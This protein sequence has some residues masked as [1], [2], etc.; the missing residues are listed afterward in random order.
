[1]LMA[2]LI[3]AGVSF[4]AGAAAWAQ[5]A[6]DLNGADV[7]IPGT[8][9]APS[10]PS[11]ANIPSPGL[12]D[13][14]VLSVT[15]S[16][17]VNATLIT[18]DGNP[19]SF[20]GT[21]T[22]GL[23]AKTAI[24]VIGGT[25]QQLLG[26]NTY[27]GGTTISGGSILAV[28][29]GSDLLNASS[30]GS[31]TVTLNGS[32]F[33]P[34]S[35][36]QNA[37]GKA[38]AFSNAFNLVGSTAT[39][40][41]TNIS[42]GGGNLTLTGAVTGVGILGISGGGTVTLDD[43]SVPGG[44]S[45]IGHTTVSG[46]ST[47]AVTTIT[48]VGSGGISLFDS[49]FKNAGNASLSFTNGLGLG[50]SGGTID[51]NMSGGGGN[52]TL[53]GQISNLTGV[54]HL[55]IVGGGTVTLD[56]SSVPGGNSY[57]GGTTVSGGS[58][59]A[60]TKHTSV[61]SGKVTLDGGTFQ[62]RADLSLFN[63]FAI[64]TGNGTID[65][66]SNTLMIFG[67]IADGNG[68]GALTKVGSGTLFLAGNN[69][70]TGGTTISGGTLQLHG[71]ITGNVIDNG[72]IAFNRGGANIFDGIISGTGALQQLGSGTTTILT[73]TNTYGGGTTISDGTLQL[74][75]GGTSGS[76]TGNVIDNGIFAINRSNAYTFGGVISGTGAFQ[77]L[78]SGITTLTGTNT[79]RGGT[80]IFA[81]TLAVT[82]SGTLG[83]T[84]NT[85]TVTG[86]GTLDLG[87]TVQTQD[88]LIQSG[89]MVLSSLPGGQINVNTYKLTGGTLDTSAIVQAATAFDMQAGTV[90]GVLT[91]TG[92]LTKTTTGTVTLT[93]IN[94]YIGGTTIS[95]GVLAVSADNNFGAASGGLIFDGGTL[96]YLSSFGTART[97]TMNSGGGTID[98]GAFNSTFSGPIGGSGAFTKIG[99]G[100]TILTGNN[101]YTGGTTISAGTLQLGNGGTTGSITGDVTNNGVFAINRSNTYTFGGV[102]SGSGAF[103]QL[104]S[105]TTILTGTN[106][107][108]GSTT[109]SGGT[110]VVNGSIAD[111]AV[112][113]NNGG[114]LAGTGTV[115]STTVESGGLF[116]PGPI[117]GSL[118]TMSV[119]GNLMFNPGATY[120]VQANPTIATS[121]SVYGVSG[122]ATLN[123][124]VTAQFLPGT[125]VAKTYNILSA[126]GGITGTFSGLGTT[127]GSV[128][129]LPAGF[130]PSLS[131]TPN[132][133]NLNLVANLQT[134]GLPPI[135]QNVGK[136]IDSYFNNGGALPPGFVNL[137]G[138]PSDKLG[139]ALTQMSGQ[140]ATGAA[141]S[142]ASMQNSFTTLLLNPYIDSRGGAS[143][144]S[145]PALGFAE[146]SSPSWTSAFDGIT[147]SEPLAAMMG[148]RYSVWGSAYGGY[149]RF[150]G[151]N[152]AG[153]HNETTRNGGLATG[154]DIRVD[155]DTVI[156]FALAG[157]ATSW[158]FS[159]GLGGG[160]S[161]MF[162]AGVYATHRF[163]AAYVSASAAYAPGWIKTDRF[164]T[165]P[166]SGHYTAKVTGQ[167][168]T[169]HIEVGN[170]FGAS[171]Y[172]FTP[173]I[174][175]NISVIALP[176]YKENT[177]TGS[178]PTFA[179]AYSSERASTGRVETG[180][181]F[182][183]NFFVD[184]SAMV[185]L[186][187]RIGYA[188]DSWS[189]AATSAGFLSLPTSSF[190]VNGLTP[191]ANLA[192]VSGVAE[193]K[194]SNGT[195]VGIKLDGEF[196]SKSL[197]FAG[198]ATFR[199]S[200]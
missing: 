49:T 126:S 193:V 84:G 122:T 90:G 195:S 157:G 55:N 154:A 89:G 26:T 150:T 92:A 58:T 139:I 162:Q 75:N 41:D 128:N 109:I 62:A 64:N 52:L 108:N 9:N 161:D 169:G 113:I 78:G 116:A 38:L 110:L 148:A 48:S 141:P 25:V 93:G 98:T 149:G 47:V 82:G 100:T 188:H 158:S 167:T 74:G 34:G 97:I 35:T 164:M 138:L 21:I 80:T 87:G 117:N 145:G 173:Y 15:N 95:G 6:I 121:A 130:A 115:G 197:S 28:T 69:T 199:Y 136:A 7:T 107:Y 29:R 14:N 180:I 125:Y 10:T 119:N 140:P 70:Y 168:F 156:G 177:A 189:N 23:N 66:Q 13:T 124:T 79:Y 151:D 135:A 160:H 32:G 159:D 36:F 77:Q 53:T 123:G 198:M 83:D 184:N 17:N 51:T 176:A 165:I 120:L 81:G 191:P 163:D 192:L 45:Y 4:G 85:T 175:G 67:V 42:G 181:W 59:V 178:D 96:R 61:G 88:K 174:G 5:V 142:T 72:I 104:G 129:T 185:A 94:T 18:G 56:D 50:G 11:A 46:G 183:Q 54:G 170:R 196:W 134:S 155:P 112:T 12:N 91:G 86:T 111:S 194:N 71:S 60:A 65:T 103:Q 152:S 144:S 44:N 127:F 22:D 132:N 33:L 106:T 24:M 99:A 37:G 146:P 73:G 76:I 16:G 147:P 101:T 137:F 43:R 39:T 63:A 114:I 30:V 118:H 3:C 27:S 179:L 31:G 57:S 171:D 2:A 166:T 102:I 187:S 8:I 143:G 105:G 200:W 172:G 133:V 20:S 1:M 153:T 182:D 131:Y 68:A 190:R 186:R 40:L 19:A